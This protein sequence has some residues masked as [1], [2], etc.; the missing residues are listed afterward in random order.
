M[1]TY[2]ANGP[3]GNTV[4]SYHDSMTTLVSGIFA[5]TINPG[6]LKIVRDIVTPTGPSTD[7]DTAVYS[8]VRA[9]YSFSAQADGTLVVANTGGVAPLDGTDLLRHM[10]KLQFADGT[11]GIIVGTPNNDTLTGTAQDDLILGLAG[12]D[13]LNGG[14]GND[15]LVGG[16]D[17]TTST[18]SSAT[19]ADN[20]NNGGLGNSTGPANW[21]P[22]W[23]ESNTSADLIRRTPAK[24]GSTSTIPMRCSFS[25]EPVPTS[26]APRSSARSISGLLQE[27]PWPILSRERGSTEHLTATASRYSSRVTGRISFRSIRSPTRH[28]SRPAIL[29]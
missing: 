10:E 1:S 15:I 12:A 9:N 5:G 13:V 22:D 11:L 27:P 17:G 16:A 2:D 6:Q 23:A 25:A 24:S 26:M 28:L 8:D 14:A 29:I 4:L 21:G 3:T 20:F 19:Y 7:I 18:A